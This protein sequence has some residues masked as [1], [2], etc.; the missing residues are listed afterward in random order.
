M[1]ETTTLWTLGAAAAGA[2]LTMKVAQTIVRR[3][4]LSAAKHPSLGGHSRM[5]KRVTKLLPG[6]AY[7]DSEFFN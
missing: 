1:S 5:A 7:S 6:Y 3:L 4:N 2:G